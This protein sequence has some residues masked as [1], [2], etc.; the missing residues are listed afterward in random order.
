MQWDLCIYFVLIHFYV[1]KL[2]FHLLYFRQGGVC[3]TDVK[4]SQVELECQF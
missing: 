4:A 1:Y 3:F 2:K